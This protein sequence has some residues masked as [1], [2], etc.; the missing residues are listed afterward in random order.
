M[1]KTKT[2]NFYSKHPFFKKTN[3][4]ALAGMIITLGMSFIPDNNIQLFSVIVIWISFFI[5]LI[6]INSLIADLAKSKG[7]SWAAF[8]W[9]SL[10]FSPLIMWIIAATISPTPGSSAYVAPSNPPKN[11]ESQD[12]AKEI[13]KLG[14]LKEK[15]FITK[16]EFDAKKKELLDRI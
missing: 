15:G 8:F 13:E 14:E 11:T 3:Y 5:I 9:L 16:A 1:P 12:L 6:G 2:S 4:I 7:R 10:L